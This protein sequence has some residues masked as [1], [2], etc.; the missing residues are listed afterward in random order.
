MALE[1]KQSLRLSQQLG[2][3]PQLQLAIKLLQLSRL[4]LDQVVQQELV[5][6]PVLEADVSEEEEPGEKPGKI[7]EELADR[8]TQDEDL[9]YSLQEYFRDRAT[10]P[11]NAFSED[12][13]RPASKS[14]M[15]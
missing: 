3:T 12:E 4:E 6:N 9:S 14:N 1:I 5:E 7:K 10:L 13:E 15:T 8:L 11:R 2:I